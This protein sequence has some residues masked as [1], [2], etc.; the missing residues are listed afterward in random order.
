MFWWFP[1]ATGVYIRDCGVATW[2]M[3]SRVFVSMLLSLSMREKPLYSNH[4][5]KKSLNGRDSYC[6]GSSV[7]CS[8]FGAF[9]SRGVSLSRNGVFRSR[10][11]P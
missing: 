9:C 3:A 8:R 11:V 7:F 6:F 4:V 1:T 2:R 5:L 10:E